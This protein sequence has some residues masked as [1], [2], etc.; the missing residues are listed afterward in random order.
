MLLFSSTTPQLNLPPS[1]NASVQ[2]IENIATFEVRSIVM[3]TP[4]WTL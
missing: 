1:T 4:L 3:G 2:L